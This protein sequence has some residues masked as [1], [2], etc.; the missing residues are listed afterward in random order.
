MRFSIVFVVIFVGV[1]CRFIVMTAFSVIAVAVIQS[2]D[3]SASITIT[4]VSPHHAKHLRPTQREKRKG[5]ERGVRAAGHRG[6]E[7][8]SL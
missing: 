7:F 2:A 1:L 6:Q 4:K 3:M 8:N 5:N